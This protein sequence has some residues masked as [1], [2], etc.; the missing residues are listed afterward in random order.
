MGGHRHHM[1]KNWGCPDNVDTN[2]SSPMLDMIYF[3][4]TGGAA[5]LLSNYAA[6]VSETTQEHWR[7]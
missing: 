4:S 3:D 5:A 2:G 6:A 7:N 1:A